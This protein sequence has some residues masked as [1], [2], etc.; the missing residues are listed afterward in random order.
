VQPSAVHLPIYS[1]ETIAAD[2]STARQKLVFC[3]VR[4]RTIDPMCCCGCPHANAISKSSVE[5]APPAPNSGSTDWTI[6]AAISA[7]TFCCLDGEL[8]GEA[9]APLLAQRADGLPVVDARGRFCGFVSS[10]APG[11]GGLPS[12][13]SSTL[14]VRDLA[15]GH[16]LAIGE[17]R[18]IG[19]ALE[20][21]ALRHARALAVVDADG[22]VR[23]V[24]TD[25]DALRAWTA[26]RRAR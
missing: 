21:M 2:G 23:G 9:A 8:T 4:E 12:R 19:E 14:R 26:L 15:V 1:R 24:L 7:L 10:A 17:E 6:V 3:P 18:S 11:S 16:A 13:L 20:A 22:N 25:I 5:C